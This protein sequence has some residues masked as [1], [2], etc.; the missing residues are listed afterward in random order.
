[1]GKSSLFQA[2][3]KMFINKKSIKLIDNRTCGLLTP[4]ILV[5]YLGHPFIVFIIPGNRNIKLML[6]GDQ[7]S[8]LYNKT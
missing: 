7:E 5:L 2:T 3:Q 1:M 4:A 6:L 8:R